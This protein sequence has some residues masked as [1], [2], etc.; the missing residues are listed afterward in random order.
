M[1]LIASPFTFGS[2]RNL[3]CRPKS[4]SLSVTLDILNLD[5]HLTPLSR[6]L[7]NTQGKKMFTWQETGS[8]PFRVSPTKSAS[9]PVHSSPLT[10][11]TCRQSS[12]LQVYF[13]S[14]HQHPPNTGPLFAVSI[15]SQSICNCVRSMEDLQCIFR[16]Y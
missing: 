7:A 16:K 5:R 6:L 2:H 10:S 11:Q 1:A 9:R 4:R 3:A 15:L 13:L 14:G 12:S 8:I